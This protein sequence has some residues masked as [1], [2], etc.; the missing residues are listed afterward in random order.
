MIRHVR[1]R[2]RPRARTF[3]HRLH[4]VQPF[5]LGRYQG[6]VLAATI[7]MM[8]HRIAY[9]VFPLLALVATAGSAA[10]WEGRAWGDIHVQTMDGATYEF[11]S[12]GEFIASRSTA[13]DLEVQLRLESTGFSSYVSIATAVA[14]LVDTS[15]VSVALGREPTLR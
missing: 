11:Q 8:T 14:V 9:V 1:G 4:R 7:G 6:T 15:R 10:A 12:S 2:W 5:V 13:G 3:R